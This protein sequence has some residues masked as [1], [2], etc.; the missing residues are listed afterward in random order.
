MV[1]TIDNAIALAKKNRYTLH[2]VTLEGEYLSPGGSMTGGA[3][4]NSSNLLA[5]NRQIEELEDKIQKLKE[6]LDECSNRK[7]DI[8]TAISL[9]NDD[10][11]K[12]KSQL[13]QLYIKQNTAKLNFD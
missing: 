11:E 5:R 6:E 7:D 9:N 8:S 13:Q 12:I 10:L 2:I 3:F 1:D 4:K